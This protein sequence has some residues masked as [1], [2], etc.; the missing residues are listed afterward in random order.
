MARADQ[1]SG[2]AAFLAVAE[3]TS[4]RAAAAELGITRAAVSLA[5]QG[6]ERRLG[7]PLFH[8]TTRSV[9]LTDAG[10][11]LLASAG[12]ASAQILRGFEAV[13]GR[14]GD[15]VGVLRLSAP[16]IAV[17]LVMALVLPEFRAA[18]PG[19]EVEL[20]VEDTNVDL[21]ARRYDAGIRIAEVIERD[22]VAVR[23]T[24]DFQW[25]VVGAPSYFARYGK[26]LAPRELLHHECVRYRFPTSGMLYRWEFQNDG[27]DFTL[28]PPGGITV[29]DHLSMIELARR[30]VGLAYTADLVAARWL[31]SGELVSVLASFLPT[32]QG[33]FLYFPANA[34][35][36]PKLRA[37]IDAA[38]VVLGARRRLPTSHLDEGGTKAP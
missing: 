18:Y 13:A 7:Q 14:G 30:G 26:P 37:F 10:E 36:P 17:D 31:Q 27:A 8:R 9:S 4:F 22:M 38:K 28:D 23:L 1:F 19:I 12:P 32:K 5:V 29:T 24:P 20:D 34:Q 33:L 6:L 3:H 35:K 21:A 11:Q 16:R 25:M 2:L 15:L